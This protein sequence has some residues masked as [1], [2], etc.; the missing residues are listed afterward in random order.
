MNKN[1]P[2]SQYFKKF[3]PIIID[4]E[5]GGLNPITDAFLEIALIAI[6]YNN[7]TLSVGEKIHCHVEPFRHAQLKKESLKFNKIDPFH[8]FR[9][10]ISEK[11]TLI[12]IFTFIRNIQRKKQ[13]KKSILIGHNVWF[14]INFLRAAIKREN[15]TNNPIN[16]CSY[17]DTAT[18]TII[19]YGE[20]VLALAM[21][22]AKI[23]F[24]H[25]ECHS[26]IYD[27]NKTAEL[28]CKTLNKL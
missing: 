24:N 25:N 17:F 12:N 27:A 2:F 22:A 6:N 9:F 5:T 4:I 1:K 21:K 18:L 20:S 15:I 19:I 10:A 3:L 11:Q 28:F 8:P 26:A 16:S 23:P 13:Y 7:D 14:D